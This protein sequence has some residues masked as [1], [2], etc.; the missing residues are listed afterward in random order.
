MTTLTSCQHAMRAHSHCI[1]CTIPTAI[2]LRLSHAKH[3]CTYIYRLGVCRARIGHSILCQDSVRV[4]CIHERRGPRRSARMMLHVHVHCVA[5]DATHGCIKEWNTALRG[6]SN[7]TRSLMHDLDCFSIAGTETIHPT[8][9]ECFSI[10]IMSSMPLV[11]VSAM[12]SLAECLRLAIATSPTSRPAGLFGSV[13]PA[14]RRPVAA[15]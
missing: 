13:F 3:I 6:K 9:T 8:N 14:T 4:Y 15:E 7:H 12:L 5:G 11:K 2:P 10:V 1:V